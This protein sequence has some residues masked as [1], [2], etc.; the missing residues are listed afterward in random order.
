[1]A[2]ASR[3]G[4]TEIPLGLVVLIECRLVIFMV[5]TQG[6]AFIGFVSCNG[7]FKALFGNLMFLPDENLKSLIG[8][9]EHLC[10][11]FFLEMSLL[12]NQSR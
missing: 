5:Q 3:G 11:I 1:V 10:L 8:R 2:L 12:E 6:M 9:R 4:N 7:F